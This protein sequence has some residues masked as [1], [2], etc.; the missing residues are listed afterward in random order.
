MGIDAVK[1]FPKE[2]RSVI[3]YTFDF[4]NLGKRFVDKTTDDCTFA[5]NKTKHCC[6][7]TGI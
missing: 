2:H 3:F 6:L 5:P 4:G 1:H 7:F